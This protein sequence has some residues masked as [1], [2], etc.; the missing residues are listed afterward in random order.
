MDP[1]DLAR[2]REAQAGAF[3]R[4]RDELRAGR[5]RSHWMWFMFP[6]IRGLGFSAMS[7][8]YGL[9]GRAEAQ[10]YLADPVLGPR[11]IELFE[12]ALT[13]E[14]SAREIFGSPDDMKLRSCATLFASL[15]GAPP[16]F[17]AALDRFFGGVADERTLAL[18]GSS[19]SPHDRGS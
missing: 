12:I 4:A 1:F 11:L 2:F 3:E 14:E 9:S 16:V 19:A 10:A 6:Q 15:P 18:A 13:R 7:Q 5:K 8:T 17:S